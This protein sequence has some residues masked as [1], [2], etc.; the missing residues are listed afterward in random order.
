MQRQIAALHEWDK[1]IPPL[2][3]ELDAE[4]AADRDILLN[5]IR[6]A[7][8]ELEVVRGWRRILTATERRDQLHLRPHGAALCAAN[9]R[10]RAVVAR[11]RLI[12]QVFVEARKNLKIRRAS[13]PRLRWS[14]STIW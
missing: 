7:L 5:S 1:K 12:P 14:R 13:I 8:L 4:P 9:V 3:R 6:G 10:L 11:E 2:T